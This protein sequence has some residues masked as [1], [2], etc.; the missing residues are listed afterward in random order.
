MA[1]YGVTLDSLKE[2]SVFVE[3]CGCVGGM[4]K[5]ISPEEIGLK[6]ED[7]PRDVSL[8]L[9]HLL[10]PV[11]LRPLYALVREAQRAALTSGTRVAKGYIIP[12]GVLDELAD[13]LDSICSQFAKEA[14]VFLDEYEDLL[15]DWGK[16][17]PEM[18]PV[19]KRAATPKEFMDERLSLTYIV[20]PLGDLSSNRGHLADK[21]ADLG[22][23]VFKEIAVEARE[24]LKKSILGKPRIGQ[25]ALRPLKRMKDKLEI[26]AWTDSRVLPVAQSIGQV[27]ARVPSKGWL[28]QDDYNWIMSLTMILSDPTMLKE[29]GAGLL[30]ITDLMPNQLGAE[31]DTDPDEDVDEDVE[32]DIPVVSPSAAPEKKFFSEAY[33]DDDADDC[34]C[35]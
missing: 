2:E 6:A 22:S 24:Y 31:S 4:S 28:S 21:A 35:L 17:N 27:L 9:K 8:V 11:R 30:S 18:A 25:K 20:L 13:N 32:F 34:F 14:T 5:S 23:G 10:D 29:H 19:I 3:V 33:E 16:K 12:T 7:L 15:E 1:T 26:L